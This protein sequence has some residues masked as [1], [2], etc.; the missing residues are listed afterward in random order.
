VRVGSLEAVREP[1]HAVEAARDQPPQDR[2]AIPRPLHDLRPDHHVVPV[3]PSHRRADEPEVPEVEVDD[4]DDLVLR[5]AHAV[6]QGEA[7]VGEIEM[8]DPDLGMGEAELLDQPPGGVGAPVL[9]GHDLERLAERPE[10]RHHPRQALAD[11]SRL[12]V[13]GHDD[14][15]GEGGRHRLRRPAP[16]SRAAA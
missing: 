2:A 7:V 10:V 6:L 9:A 15:E 16:A 1:Q 3:Q 5:D 8:L 14:G 11:D 13:D 4:D 12:V